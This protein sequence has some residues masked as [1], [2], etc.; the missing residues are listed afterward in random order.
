[1]CGFKKIGGVAGF[2]G[3]FREIIMRCKHIGVGL[4]VMRQSAC[5]VIGPIA[6]DGCAA[7]FSCT[8]MDRASGS[9]V[10]PTWSCSF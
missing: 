6:V 10:A 3:Q 4:G 1:M 9:M 7:L 8:P 2:S 5:L